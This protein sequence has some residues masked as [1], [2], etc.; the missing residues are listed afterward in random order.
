[1]GDYD[2][3]WEGKLYAGGKHVTNGRIQW[4]MQGP[5]YTG[6]K[7]HTPPLTAQQIYDIGSYPLK[8][9]V[10]PSE[11]KTIGLDEGTMRADGGLREGQ[12]TVVIMCTTYEGW[13]IDA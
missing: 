7:F 11:E 4:L 13:S 1:M 12:R 5:K 8:M 3:L 10:F 9:A 6:M 2:D